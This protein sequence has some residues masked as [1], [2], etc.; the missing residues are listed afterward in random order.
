VIPPQLVPGGITDA[1][2][3]AGGS[4]QVT[5]ATTVV[6]NFALNILLAGSLN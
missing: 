3:G 6:G 4:L 1:I 5:S 2:K